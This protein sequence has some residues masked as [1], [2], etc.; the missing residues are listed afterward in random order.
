M[1][2]FRFNDPVVPGLVLPLAQPDSPGDIQLNEGNPIVDLD[3]SDVD[4]GCNGDTVRQRHTR[5]CI[6]FEPSGIFLVEAVS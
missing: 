4:Y 2:L 3:G 6:A 5:S 1:A